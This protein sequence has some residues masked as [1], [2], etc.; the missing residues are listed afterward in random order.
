MSWIAADGSD[1]VSGNYAGAQAALVAPPA[2]LT[3]AADTAFVFASQVHH[4]WVQNNSSTVVGVEFDAPASAGSWQIPANGGAVLLDVPVTAV[5][6]F[7]TAA[8]PVNGTAAGNI[9]VK[10]W[11]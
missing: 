3:A 10:G 5:H 11:S 4:V 7:S 6:L 9:V 2:N 8:S 1:V